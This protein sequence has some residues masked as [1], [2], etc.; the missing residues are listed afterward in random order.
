[1]EDIAP[2][3]LIFAGFI[4]GFIGSE[5]G[6]GALV[7]LPVLLFLGLPPA[8]A[9]ATNV[10]SAWLINAVAS[11][12]YFKTH[13]VQ[14]RIV[15]HLAPVALV[16]AII[17]AELIIQL[18][19]RT[20]S[21]IVAVLFTFVFLVLFALLR[22]GTAGLK[23]G[24]SAFS[25]ARKLLAAGFVFGLGVYGGFFAVGVTTLFVIMIV[26]V[27]RRDFMQAAADAVWISAVFLLG[28]LVTF[29]MNGLIEWR[30]AIPLAL[31][32]VVGA[33]VGTQAAVK[34][35]NRWLKGLVMTIV[36]LVV[37]KLAYQFLDGGS[38][39]ACEA[40]GLFCQ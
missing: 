2:I 4:G 23:A 32:S 34:F 24:S 38:V 25:G 33:H 8:A 36:I 7:T 11:Y 21:A 17:G 28:S 39:L 40:I 5:V 12:D 22:H 29:S 31:G 18:D 3:I 16:G 6:A 37:V 14:Q 15:W 9:V 10:L 26:Y 27:L 30:L 20:A 1:M 35:G 19:Q 13:K